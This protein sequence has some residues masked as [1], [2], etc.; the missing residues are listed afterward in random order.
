[1][2]S[3]KRL[4]RAAYLKTLEERKKKSRVH[5]RHQLVGLEIAQCLRDDTHKSL[6]MKLA[7]ECNADFLLALA[8]DVAGRPRVKNRGAYFM[9][10][11]LGIPKRVRT[12]LKPI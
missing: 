7:K 2:R 1:M 12:R 6:Y 5:T 11:L 10:L 3:V 8:K 9:R 4:S